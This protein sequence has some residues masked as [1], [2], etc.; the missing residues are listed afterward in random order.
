MVATE[1]QFFGPTA[2]NPGDRRVFPTTP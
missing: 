1:Q 2:I